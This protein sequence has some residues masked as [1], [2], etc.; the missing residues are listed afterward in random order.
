MAHPHQRLIDLLIPLAQK[1]TGDI[2]VTLKGKSW[3][4][5]TTPDR[6]NA[7]I[8]RTNL[9]HSIAAHVDLMMPAPDPIY[10]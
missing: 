5:S 7:K 10:G 6:H 9:Q 1:S 4:I 2:Y 3:N 8:D